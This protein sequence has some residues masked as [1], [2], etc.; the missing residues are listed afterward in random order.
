MLPKIEISQL[1]LYNLNKPTSMTSEKK[2]SKTFRDC[3]LDLK[4][5]GYILVFTTLPDTTCKKID[6]SKISDKMIILGADKKININDCN[7]SSVKFD[8]DIGVIAPGGLDTSTNVKVTSN[9]NIS[10]VHKRPSIAWT[11]ELTRT[12][13]YLLFKELLEPNISGAISIYEKSK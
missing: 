7:F 3:I 11:L 2:A 6:D 4:W 13:A 1:I 9:W 5:R 8:F 12:E 10:W